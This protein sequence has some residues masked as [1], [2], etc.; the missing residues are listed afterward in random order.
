MEHWELLQASNKNGTPGAF[1]LIWWTMSY[2]R[3]NLLFFSPKMKVRGILELHLSFI[4]RKAGYSS[5]QIQD[6][7]GHLGK[8]RE[9]TWSLPVRRPGWQALQLLSPVWVS[10]VSGLLPRLRLLRSVT[11]GAGYLLPRIFQTH[12]LTTWQ[13]V[14]LETAGKS[15]K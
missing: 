1:T 13:P 12:A 11:W 8:G 7:E 2:H 10:L 5:N 6:R 3:E 15:R 14:I 4:L 9:G